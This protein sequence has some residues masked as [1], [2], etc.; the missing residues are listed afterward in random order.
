MFLSLLVNVLLHFQLRALLASFSLFSSSILFLIFLF[1]SSSL[2]VFL[3]FFPILLYFFSFLGFF[4]SF[5]FFSEPDQVFYAYLSFICWDFSPLIFHKKF[6]KISFRKFSCFFEFKLENL[7][8]TC[9]S[10]QLHCF[11]LSE[12]FLNLLNCSFPIKIIIIRKKNV[13]KFILL[14][15]NTTPSI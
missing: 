13:D 14:P 4:Y 10:A 2:S 9:I 1:S 8:K 6:V 7:S 15:F 3:S 11:V 12:H 5:L